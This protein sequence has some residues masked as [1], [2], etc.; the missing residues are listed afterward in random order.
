M[1]QS[2]RFLT[3][4]MIAVMSYSGLLT[5]GCMGTPARRGARGPFGRLRL[6]SSGIAGG[7]SWPACPLAGSSGRHPGC[8]STES[9]KARESERA[10]DTLL[11][12]SEGRPEELSPMDLLSARRDRTITKYLGSARR[13]SQA[14]AHTKA[15]KMKAEALRIKKD[16][17]EEP[18]KVKLSFIKFNNLYSRM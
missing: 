3:N 14:D 9:G 8:R 16:W 6:R 10:A 18:R 1:H 17:I 15:K 4:D 12:G 2:R 7:H 5:F 11:Q 13:M